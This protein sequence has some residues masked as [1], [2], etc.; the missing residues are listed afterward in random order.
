MPSLNA[1]GELR[2]VGALPISANTVPNKLFIVS[3]AVGT[4]AQQPI[5]YELQVNSD[6]TFTASTTTVSTVFPSTLSGNFVSSSSNTSGVPES[7]NV[8][9]IGSSPPAGNTTGTTT[10]GTNT[11]TTT[12]NTTTATSSGDMFSVKSSA[13]GSFGIY[14]GDVLVD[15]LQIASANTPTAWNP[16]DA[17]RPTDGTHVFSIKPTGTTAS[18][19]TATMSVMGGAFSATT[20]LKIVPVASLPTAALAANDTAYYVIHDL[21]QTIA[22]AATTSSAL[23][24]L[25]GNKHVLGVFS[26]DGSVPSGSDAMNTLTLASGQTIY[27]LDYD[28]RWTDSGLSLTLASSTRVIDEDLNN[29]GTRLAP[30]LESG[31]NVTAP[32]ATGADQINI[33]GLTTSNINGGHLKV[34]VAAAQ[35][36]STA[37]LSLIVATLSGVFK[38]NATT[39]AVDYYAGAK[40]YGSEVKDAAG[41]VMH[42]AGEAAVYGTTGVTVATIDS[43]L[44]GKSGNALQLN[45]NANATPEVV[46]LLASHIAMQVLDSAGNYT[47]VWDAA[48]GNKTVTFELAT[49]VTGQVATAQRTV[50]VV[51]HEENGQPFLSFLKVIREVDEDANNTGRLIAFNAAGP[52]VYNPGSA[53]SN[54][55]VIVDDNQNFNGGSLTVSTISGNMSQ[56]RLGISQNSGVFKVATNGEVTYYSDATY[57]GTEVRDANGNV[58]NKT[59]DPKQAGTTANSFVIGKIDSLHQGRLGDYLTIQF[60]DKA[61]P[62]IVQTLASSIYLGVTDSTGAMT[63]NWSAAAGEKLIEFK[64]KDSAGAT[65]VAASRVVTIISHPEDDGGLFNVSATAAGTPGNGEILADLVIDSS[66]TALPGYIATANGLRVFQ[67]K[68]SDP[69]TFAVSSTS[70]TGS[71]KVGTL[72][73]IDSDAT[74][75][76]PESFS[77]Q[78]QPSTILPLVYASA[79]ATTP[80]S[81]MLEDNMGNPVNVPLTL[82]S[83]TAPAGLFATF[84]AQV[85][86]DSNVTVTLSGKIWDKSGDGVPDLIEGTMGSDSFSLPLT[87]EDVNGDGKADQARAMDPPEL[88]TGRVAT[89]SAGLV[90]GFFVPVDTGNTQPSGPSVP[91]VLTVSS[92]TRTFDEDLN[93]RGRRVAFNGE[94]GP[95][96]TAPAAAGTNQLKLVDSDSASFAGGYLKVSV[97]AASGGSVSGLKLGVS[98]LSGVFSIS[99]TGA[100]SYSPDATYYGSD[101]KDA[102][103]KLLHASG[104]PAKAGTTWVQIGQVDSALNGTNGAAFKVT[105]NSAATSSIVETFAS[106][107]GLVPLDP[108]TGKYTQNW[109]AVQGEKTVTYE[110]TDGPTGTAVTASRVVTLTAQAE[111]GVP[112]ISL[113][114]VIRSIDEDANN[115]GRLIAFNGE[116]G[117]NVVMPSNTNSNQVVILDSDSANF[118]GGSLTVSVISGN[119][120]QLRLGISTNSG[121]FKVNS[122]TREISYVSDAQYYGTDVKDSAGN[123]VNKSFSNAKAGTTSVV[124]G[125]LDTTHQ[126]KAGDYLSIQL[127]DKATVAIT[128]L[129]AAHIYLGVTDVNG[130]LTQNWSAAAGEKLI[131]FKIKDSAAGTTTT[132][133]R[134]MEIISHP[135]DDFAGTDGDDTFQ[136]DS[137]GFYDAGAGNDTVRGSSGNDGI[138]G[139]AGNDSLSGGAGNDTL[140]GGPGNDTLDGGDGTDFAQYFDSKSTDWTITAKS[141]GFE[142]VNKNTNEKDV[143]SNIEVLQFND[144]QKNLGVNYWAAPE[145]QGSNSINGSEFADNIDADAL[146]AAN[147]AASKRDWINGG[148]GNDTIKG[149]L[150]GDDITGGAG[151]DVIDGGS[152]GVSGL[153]STLLANP[154]ANTWELENRAYY[155]GPANKYEI[156]SEK[157]NGVMTY[158]IKDLRT[159]S[160]DGTDTVTNVDVL[161]FSDKQ[162][163]LTPNLWIDRGWDAEKGQPGTTPK[164][165]NLEGSGV[166]DVLGDDS[167]TYAGSDRLIGNDGNDVLKGGAGA[168]TFRGD[169]GNDTIDGGANRAESAT[170]TWDSNGSNGVDVAEYSGPSSRY[171][172]TKN[173]DTFTVTDSKGA[174]GDGTD[175]LTNVEV[176]RFS[177]GEKNLMVVKTPQM[178]FTPGSTTGTITGYNWNGTDLAD[179][180]NTQPAGANG[181]RDWVT[182]GAGNDSISTGDGGDWIDA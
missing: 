55:V 114:P 24:T 10:T 174:A 95:N 66:A 67:D 52:N 110:V 158:T 62:A 40:Y 138:N 179:T 73:L 172:I 51:S 96:V 182:A 38:V 99:S 134:A 83:S 35:G 117:P 147:N 152:V 90:T 89:D 104:D 169:K 80:S 11:G 7:V 173:G 157:V 70:T 105:F 156:K 139:G 64:L 22:Q 18:T 181:A 153:L 13:P 122:T 161:Q 77:A 123:I 30:V 111:N 137:A 36:G 79:T 27:I 133:T 148:D 81:F 46:E 135:E 16:P 6:T 175:T 31:S 120:N 108:T 87:M 150:G 128:Q 94:A 146:G 32:A 53:N 91:P 60:T 82:A 57:Y 162:V 49:N 48:A 166:D 155:S 132:A 39:G 165:I 109:E 28:S 23:A 25:V 180:I 98:N 26:K 8:T 144:T 84:T 20:T 129:L 140:S 159:N 177:D 29:I 47:Q 103:G 131:E 93:N 130:N 42:K 2:Y 143:L 72:K 69:M 41:N 116:A 1:R 121:V 63:Q 92:A 85:K 78:L 50:S 171:T 125:T 127:N 76:G 163:R 178:N 4:T 37:A 97:A 86:N 54:Q 44:N 56:L 74:K 136:L 71:V 113:L 68:D 112:S 19:A 5:V 107:V 145:A 154:Q 61:T 167:P 21:Q 176:L 151:N 170:Q 106:H 149:G 43:A 15:T 142:L 168:D 34:S 102:T 3:T 141:G 101:V 59:F 119:M 45:F 160:P 33:T 126:G 115:T 88:V 14:D 12:G 58:V 100:V 164:G 118:N 17:Y 9:Q 75:A 124:I 65:A